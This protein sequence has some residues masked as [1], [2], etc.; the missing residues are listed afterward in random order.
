M[1]NSKYSLLYCIILLIIVILIDWCIYRNEKEP[2]YYS[3]TT[4][5]TTSYLENSLNNS[6][7]KINEVRLANLDNQFRLNDI[8]NRANNISMS[9]IDLSTKNKPV[10]S[11]TFY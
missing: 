9:L 2:F 6:Y 11:L 7:N 4:P 5:A 8:T 3:T 10:G 1:F